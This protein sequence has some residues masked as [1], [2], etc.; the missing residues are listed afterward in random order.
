MVTF[1][2][3]IRKKSA[4]LK[5]QGEFR[6]ISAKFISNFKIPRLTEKAF[7][8]D[9]SKLKIPKY[10]ISNSSKTKEYFFT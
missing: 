9:F 5:R 4:M 8:L 3:K 2:A 10:S 6:R 1:P 7:F